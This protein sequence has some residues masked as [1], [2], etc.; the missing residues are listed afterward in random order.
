MSTA[1]KALLEIINDILD[2]SKI[3]AGKLELDIIETD[4]PELIRQTV[5]IFKYTTS[6]QGIEFSLSYDPHSPRFIQVDPVRLKQILINLL[7]NA[8]K[9]TAKG[10]INLSVSFQQ[11]ANQQSAIKQSAIQQ[12]ANQES[13]IQ[14]SANQESADSEVNSEVNSEKGNFCFAVSDT[15]IGITPEQ[16]QRLFK[17]FSQGDGS[18]TRRFGGTGLGL[19][20]SRDRKSVV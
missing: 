15:G 14:Q 11:S 18:T 19:V 9:F 20:I 4:L 2:F 3:E 17:A 13:A 12:S 5:E 16:Q 7:S 8:V 10:E 6:K 1:G